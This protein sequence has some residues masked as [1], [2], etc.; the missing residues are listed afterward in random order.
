M[1]AFKFINLENVDMLDE[2]PENHILPNIDI[3]VGVLEAE[4]GLMGLFKTVNTI[5]GR[6]FTKRIK[7]VNLSLSVN[8]VK[9]VSKICKVVI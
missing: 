1:N 4:D 3:D 9:L 8:S 5:E 2:E 6:K 7:K